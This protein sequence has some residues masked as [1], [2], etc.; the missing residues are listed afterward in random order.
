MS[1]LEEMLKYYDY[2]MCD[3]M[4]ALIQTLEEL[5]KRGVEHTV[6]EFIQVITTARDKVPI[7]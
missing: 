3:G 6:Q 5:Q 2:G 7:V 4:T 1:S